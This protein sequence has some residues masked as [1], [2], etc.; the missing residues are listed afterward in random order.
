MTSQ[1]H[2]RPPAGYMV[3]VRGHLG[4]TMRRAFPTLQARTDG[5]DTLLQGI[6][7]QAALHGVL[8][9]VEALRLELLEV[10]RLPENNTRETSQ[11]DT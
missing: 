3:R 5:H 4:V 11:P 2:N 6:A 10:R 1:Q 9:R 7:D 8:A